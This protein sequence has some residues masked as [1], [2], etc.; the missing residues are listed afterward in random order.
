MYFVIRERIL[1][2]L[3]SMLFE[4]KKIHE[5]SPFDSKKN[6]LILIWLF[7][8]LLLKPIV[9]LISIKLLAIT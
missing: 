7:C 6:T 5:A 4:T 3:K 2:K 1:Q 9:A 8:G